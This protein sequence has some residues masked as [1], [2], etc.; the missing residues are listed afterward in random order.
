MT[1]WDQF[2]AYSAAVTMLTSPD[3][4]EKKQANDSSC[5]VINFMIFQC[6]AWEA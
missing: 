2:A 5:K 6:G 4:S 3:Q 1:G